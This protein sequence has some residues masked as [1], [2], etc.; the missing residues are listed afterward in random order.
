MDDYNGLR[1]SVPRPQRTCT[2]FSLTREVEGLPVTAYVFA[3][4]LLYC[5]AAFFGAFSA[6][7]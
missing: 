4:F 6:Q 3:A 5:D 1:V 2:L 7:H